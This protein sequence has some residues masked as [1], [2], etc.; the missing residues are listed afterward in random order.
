VVAVGVENS[1][2]LA[3]GA[4]AEDWETAAAPTARAV[5]AV[6]TAGEAG[7]AVEV[8]WSG[9]IRAATQERVATLEAVVLLGEAILAAE[10]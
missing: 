1:P 7:A 6:V 8:E 3:P 9:W 4:M 5:Q 10:A 2:R